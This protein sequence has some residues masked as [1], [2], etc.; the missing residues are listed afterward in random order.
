MDARGR[1]RILQRHNFGRLM[2]AIREVNHGEE[3]TFEQILIADNPPPREFL[4]VDRQVTDHNMHR[5][6]DLLG[7]RGLESG[8]WGRIT[9]DRM[10]HDRD[11]CG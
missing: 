9:Q 7:M 5:R 3:R 11:L 10:R 6:L 1:H 8:G 4:L 2:K